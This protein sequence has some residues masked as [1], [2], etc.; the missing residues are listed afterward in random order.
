MNH[1]V[2][3]ENISSSVADADE[4]DIEQDYLFTLAE[5][6]PELAILGAW[7]SLEKTLYELIKKNN[8]S[9]S[10][11]YISNNFTKQ[12]YTNDLITK[13]QREILEELRT[14]RNKAVHSHITE[15]TP[16]LISTLNYITLAKNLEI[17][18][19]NTN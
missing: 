9:E 7:Q 6:K 1:L 19:K 18:L 2:Q 14:L 5:T 13:R 8:I 11:K 3:E 4:T 17:E 16:T 10:K 15:F 12:L